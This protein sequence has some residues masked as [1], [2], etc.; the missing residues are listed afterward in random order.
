MNDR[1]GFGEYWRSR[2]PM[3]LCSFGDP[4]ALVDIDEADDDLRVRWRMRGETR[5]AVFSLSPD[6]AGTSRPFDRRC[7]RDS[8][9]RRQRER[10]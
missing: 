9:P 1:N 6:A 8:P 4:G 5:E 7:P 10:L 3:D 2:I